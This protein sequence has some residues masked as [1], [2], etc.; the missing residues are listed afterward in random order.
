MM[1]PYGRS[2]N[3]P[4][5]VSNLNDHTSVTWDIARLEEVCLPID[6]SAILWIPLCTTNISDTRAWNFERNGFF[7]IRSA[8]K[9]IIDTKLRR[10]AWLDGASGSSS[11]DRDP[12]SWKLLW[13]TSVP[14]KMRMFLWILAKHSLPTEDVR[15]HRNMSTSSACGLCGAEDSW[16]HSMLECSVARCIWT[17]VD[18]ELAEHYL[19]E[20]TE[21]STKQ[22]DLH[23]D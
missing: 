8:Y 11:N 3:P 5:R 1:C 20:A 21:P 6:V 16:R 13:K 14:G 22:M 23:N 12:D 9:M 2:G 4:K 17:L 18:G 10:E 7:S 15:A 19:C